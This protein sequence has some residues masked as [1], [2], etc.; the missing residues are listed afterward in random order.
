MN[1]VLNG[2]VYADVP[3]PE[4]RPGPADRYPQIIYG[5]IFI[6]LTNSAIKYTEGYMAYL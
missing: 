2:P 5:N 6:A 1:A 4:F 3:R